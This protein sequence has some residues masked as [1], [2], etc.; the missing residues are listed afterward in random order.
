MSSV[1]LVKG[2][3]RRRNVRRALELIQDDLASLRAARRILIKPNL[4]ATGIAHA[5]THADCVRGVL[6]FCAGYLND[7]N[8]K[9]FTIL[10][11]SGSAYYEHCSTRDVFTRFGY[12]DLARE[13]PNLALCTIEEC[14]DFIDV[15][16]RSIAGP[17]RVGLASAI[18]H[19]DYRISLNL[20]KTHNYAIAT[21]GIKNMMGLLRQCDKSLIHGLRTPS[22]PQA[23]TVFSYIP[24]AWI[25]WTRRRAPWL[26][27]TLFTH[28]VAYLRAVQV[29]HHNVVAVAREAWPDLVVLDAWEG[30]EG[31]GPVD[32]RRVELRAAVASADA[33]KADGVGARLMGFAPEEIGYLYYLGQEGRGEYSLQGLRGERVESVAVRFRRHPTYEIQRQ[34]R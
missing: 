9:R 21:L 26:V 27:N 16:V 10:E 5:N 23:K 6:D 28:S 19:F 12:D 13:Y 34:W 1:S 4:T 30:M 31:D 3:D 24:T 17:E 2:D 33:L 32:G 15:P 18:R 7:F 22:A 14:I 25:A 20:P 8:A 11:G 29:I